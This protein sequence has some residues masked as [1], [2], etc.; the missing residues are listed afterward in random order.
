MFK[1]IVCAKKIRRYRWLSNFIR[2]TGL[3]EH[4]WQ[5]RLAKEISLLPSCLSLN[6]WSLPNYQW[7]LYFSYYNMYIWC[8]NLFSNDVKNIVDGWMLPILNISIEL[9]SADKVLCPCQLINNFRFP[10]MSLS[11]PLSDGLVSFWSNYLQEVLSG[12]LNSQSD[13]LSL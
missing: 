7:F 5:M 9:R 4:L 8:S 11:S 13:H 6:H 12:Q 3:F 1:N 10:P 2:V